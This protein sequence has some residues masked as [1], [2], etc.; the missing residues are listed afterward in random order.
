[1]HSAPG[2]VTRSQSPVCAV[3]APASSEGENPRGPEHH[4]AQA[5]ERVVRM[6]RIHVSGKNNFDSNR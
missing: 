1:L 2:S 6:D 4:G 3:D 5:G